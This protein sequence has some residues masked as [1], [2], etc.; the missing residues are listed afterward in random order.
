[1]GVL[2]KT[3]VEPLLALDRVVA[4]T[5]L[6]TPNDEGTCENISFRR[7]TLTKL[8]DITYG[9]ALSVDPSIDLNLLASLRSAIARNSGP[10]A[11][12]R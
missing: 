7:S 1:M 4:K 8:A 10:F 9:K 11:D 3:A 2:A 5:Q 12:L 6:G